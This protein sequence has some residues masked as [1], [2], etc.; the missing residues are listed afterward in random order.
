MQKTKVIEFIKKHNMI[1]CGDT[2]LAAVSGGADSVCMLHMLLNL[3][4]NLDFSVCAAHFNHMLRGAEADRD[5]AFVKDLCENLQ[6]PFYAGRGDVR[7]FAEENGKS[8]EEAARILRYDFL[9][10]TALKLNSAKIATAHNADDNAETVILNLTR[11]TGLSGIRG[12]PPTRENIIRP[13]L[14]LT[15]DEIETF[16]NTK[17]IRYVTDSSNLEDVYSRNKLRHNVM[18]VLKEINPRFAEG[19]LRTGDLIRQDEE[20]LSGE[21]DRIISENAN[22]NSI[23]AP[24]LLSLPQSLSSRVIRKLAGANLAAS[25]VEDVLKLCKNSSPSAR[26]NLPGLTVHREYDSII[27]GDADKKEFSP[28]FIQSGDCIKLPEL[29]IEVSME[30]SVFADNINK[31][32]TE[33]LFKTG[34]NIK[35]R[36]TSCTKTLKKLFTEKRIPLAKRASVPIMAD[37][38]GVLGVYKIGCDVRGT[39]SLG[40]TIYIIKFKEMPDK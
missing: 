40:D 11:G 36:E 25:F 9:Q 27:F 33:Y 19:F 7:A 2:V 13:L 6:I 8:T 20:Y 12:I 18:P 3:A 15:R 24:L 23:N 38:N 32:F 14:C 29:G 31:S 28:I 39:P 35:L 22:G 21:A 1:S 17:G 30:T 4:E 26:L 34:D 10:K 37:D 16:L 5:E